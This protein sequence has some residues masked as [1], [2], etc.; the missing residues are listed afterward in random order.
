M[1]MWWRHCFTNRR[2]AF[3]TLL[4]H[5][6]KILGTLLCLFMLHIVIIKSQVSSTGLN[7]QKHRN[8]VSGAQI[9]SGGT[10]SHVN[11]RCITA[12]S[13]LQEVDGLPKKT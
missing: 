1:R 10:L 11:A 12:S 4:S 13:E 5:E 6:H 8:S 9:V 7:L 2:E 3:S